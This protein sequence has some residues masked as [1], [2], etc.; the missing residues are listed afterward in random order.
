MSPRYRKSTE[1]EERS[2]TTKYSVGWWT[3]HPDDG[4]PVANKLEYDDIR[5][6]RRA[7]ADL[8]PSAEPT[9]TRID[10]SESTRTWIA[11]DLIGR[12]LSP[13]QA[14]GDRARGVEMLRAVL[15]HKRG[16][17]SRGQKVPG[18]PLKLGELFE[19]GPMGTRGHDHRNGAAGCPVCSRRIAEEDPAQCVVCDYLCEHGREPAHPFAGLVQGTLGDQIEER[20]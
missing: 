3:R 5:A 17:D 18:E 6:A 12:A 7:Y 20:F 15:A 11:T 10:W 14:Q 8:S 1:T 9:A 13:E 2:V 16:I 4:T 19:N